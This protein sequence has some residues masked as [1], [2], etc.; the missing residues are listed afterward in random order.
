MSGI[1][2]SALSG[3]TT[4]TKSSDESTTKTLLQIIAPS[5]QRV[6]I[7]RWGVFFNEE[8]GDATPAIPFTVTVGKN[9][10]TDGSGGGTVTLTKVKPTPITPRTVANKNLTVTSTLTSE[11]DLAYVN[12]QTGYEV[13]YPMGQEIELDPSEV[14]N[15]LVSSGSVLST[16]NVGVLAKVWIEE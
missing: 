2:L 10:T 9:T 16:G 7:L 11:L 1:I 5:S 14:F 4:F 12:A 15:V 6:K 13:I 3:V 8:T